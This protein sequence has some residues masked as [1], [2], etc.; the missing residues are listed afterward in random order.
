MNQLGDMGGPESIIGNVLMANVIVA[1]LL[2]LLCG[3]YYPDDAICTITHD[4]HF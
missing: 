4:D 3:C 1:V 2:L